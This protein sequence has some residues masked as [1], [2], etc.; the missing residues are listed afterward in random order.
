MPSKHRNDAFDGLRG[1]A[2]VAVVAYHANQALLPGGYIGVTVFFVLAGYL[3][4]MSVTRR[5]SSEKG[6]S[7]PG[8]IVSRVRRPV[9]YTHLAAGPFVRAYREA[10]GRRHAP[11]SRFLHSDSTAATSVGSSRRHE[12]SLR[13]ESRSGP[14]ASR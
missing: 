9:S 8:F 12:P 5:L 7:Y 13:R 10:G 1:L 3:A 6:F 2:I 14:N 4:T 11:F